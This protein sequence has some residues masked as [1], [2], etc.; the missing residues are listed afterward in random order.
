MT[1]FTVST[2]SRRGRWLLQQ[3]YEDE[4]NRI[5][6][7]VG[8]VSS[9]LAERTTTGPDSL[10]TLPRAVDY[11]PGGDTDGAAHGAGHAAQVGAAAAVLS[12]VFS[13]ADPQHIYRLLEEEFHELEGACTAVG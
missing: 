8:A 6:D 13:D 10:A 1:I 12:A 2:L 9:L 11:I 5:G 4:H 3:E 7:P